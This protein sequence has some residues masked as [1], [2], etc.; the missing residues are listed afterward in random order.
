MNTPACVALGS[1][2][3]AGAAVA[4]TCFFFVY[5]L[6]R[7]NVT[8]RD[9]LRSQ[10]DELDKLDS[11]TKRRVGEKTLPDI[12][13]DLRRAADYSAPVFATP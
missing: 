9:M 8:M 2:L 7:E 3:S 1:L 11:V 13:T 6:R 12:A 10:A 4:L 5:P